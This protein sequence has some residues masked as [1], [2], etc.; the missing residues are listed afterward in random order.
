MASASRVPVSPVAIAPPPKKS[1]ESCTVPLVFAHP[2]S[3]DLDPKTSLQSGMLKGSTRYRMGR[4]AEAS[5]FA[6]V[7]LGPRRGCMT[8]PK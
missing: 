5:P 1:M 2:F 8:W 6:L 7:Q 4:A 3:T